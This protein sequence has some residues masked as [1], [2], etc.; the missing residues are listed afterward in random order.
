[1]RRFSPDLSSLTSSRVNLQG[2]LQWQI[3]YNFSHCT[4]IFKLQLWWPRAPME[5]KYIYL[6]P[7]SYE[8]I[9]LA[10]LCMFIT[11][12]NETIFKTLGLRQF[13][14]FSSQSSFSRCE[15]NINFSTSY[16]NL[17]LIKNMLK[18]EKY[19]CAIVRLPSMYP[20]MC[21]FCSPHKDAMFWL[22]DPSWL[23]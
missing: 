20:Y 2:C 9:A 23:L 11:W 12:L 8:I 5:I 13:K 22:C 10:A 14:V 21:M 1:M 3:L 6:S 7:S 17:C 4:L 18:K 19:P 15:V 16:T